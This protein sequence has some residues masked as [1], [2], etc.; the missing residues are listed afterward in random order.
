MIIKLILAAYKLNLVIELDQNK[1]EQNVL[2]TFRL[3]DLPEELM[4]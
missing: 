2:K 3:Q 1:L 4:E